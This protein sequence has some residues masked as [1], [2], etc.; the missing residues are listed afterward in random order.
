MIEYK[1][2]PE[3]SVHNF[4]DILNRSGLGERRPVDNIEVITG[5]I[6]NAVIIVTA[7]D[8]DKIVGIARAVTDFHYCCYLS[9]LAVDKE[10]Q[11]RGIGKTL[12]SKLKNSLHKNC[13]IILLSA[14]TA[15]EYYPKI[16]FEKHNS[17]WVLR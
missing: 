12:I 4:I 15:T 16:G 1:I 11:H 6:K 5:M 9:D 7:Y 3:I 13:K 17:A 8:N 14:P 2:N 10:Y